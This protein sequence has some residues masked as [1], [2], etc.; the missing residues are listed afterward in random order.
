MHKDFA[1]EFIEFVDLSPSPFH[2]V[3]TCKKLL[4][5]EGYEELN[6]KDKWNLKEEKGYFVTKNNSS[7][8][9]FYINSNDIKKGFKIIGSHTDF[10][11]IKIK[12][13]PEII[14][15][16]TYLKFNTEIY[17]G[18]IL[19]TWLD[20]PLS[21][22]GRVFTKSNDVFNPDEYLIDFKRPIAIIPNLAIHVNP[23]VNQGIELNK[24]KDMLPLLSMVDDTFNKD[25]FLIKLTSTNIN[26]VEE[27]ILDFELYL[28]DNSKGS[29][30]GLN[31]EFV[32]CRNLDNLAMVHSSLMALLDSNNQVS[33]KA[34]NMIAAFDN[35]EIGSQTKQGADSMFLRTVMNRVAISLNKNQE[36]F[37]RGLYNSFMISADGAHALHPNR[38]Q[39]HDPTN[40]P[41][42]NNGPVIKISANQRYTSDAHSISVYKSICENNDIPYQKFVNP[43][44]KRGG[45][46]IGPI[47]SSFVDISSIDL[48]IPMLAMHSIR[49]LTGT[50][51]L[52]L[53]YK[54]FVEFFNL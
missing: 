29:L 37:I 23:K 41:I 11:S 6:L 1:K 3:N 25:N 48:G 44:D 9:A 43:S 28:Y 7:L 8:I 4:K 46:T 21:I 20:R 40:K 2:V 31:E 13:K 54:S 32:S 16:K 35:E 17:G 19:N 30:V 42:L 36:E 15:E 45:S 49:E 18:P 53:T 10:P 24:Q 12:P 38:L 27:N 33:N 52:Y 14:G 39:D 47:S 34:V 51:D 5:K 22:A 50:K 26:V